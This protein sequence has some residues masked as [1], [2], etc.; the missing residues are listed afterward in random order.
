MQACYYGSS[1]QGRQQILLGKDLHDFVSL[2]LGHGVRFLV[3]G[4]YAVAAHGHPRLTRDLDVW[5]WVDP[6][7]AARMVAALDEFGF[8][9]LGLTTEDFSEE[10]QVVHLGNPPNRIDVLTS[11]AGVDFESCWDRRAE[12]SL[13]SLAVPF[14]GL[15][16]LEKNKLAAGRTQDIAD[17]EG[18]RRSRPK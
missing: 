8:A 15:D 18:L 7:N 14:I 10:G 4:G 6:E 12:I 17:V 13:D 11:I 3:V 9:A 16:D 1:G 2:C 5:V